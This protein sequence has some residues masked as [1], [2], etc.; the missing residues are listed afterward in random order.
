MLTANTLAF[1]IETIPD[2]ELAA[3]LFDL[4]D[5]SP[6][7]QLRAL[8]VKRVEKTGNSDFFAHHM[9][10]IIAISAALRSRDGFKI[11]T[12]GEPD[13]SEAELLE[14]FFRGLDRFDP[15]LISWNGTGFDLPVIHYRS[16]LHSV[17]SSRYWEVGENDRSFRYNNYSNRFHWRHIDLMDVLAG[18]QGRASAPLHEIAMM[19]DL[20]GKIGM[21]GGDVWDAYIGNHIDTIRNYCE[22]DVLNTYL[23]YLRF[24]RIRGNLS[25]IEFRKETDLVRSTVEE[26]SQPHLDEFLL[27]WPRGNSD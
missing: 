12:L 24:E 11:W 3:K 5:L 25:A 1:D 4:K 6:E 23:I 16:L 9:H 14:R 7:D 20:P 15:V 19:L 18:F 26:E 13:S 8:R 21:N 22:T 17:T 27:H 2:T 10:R